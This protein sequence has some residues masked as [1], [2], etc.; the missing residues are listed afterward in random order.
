MRP[1]IFNKNFKS[2]FYKAYLA[3]FEQPV[4]ESAK[5]LAE[6][7][8]THN[9]KMDDSIFVYYKAPGGDVDEAAQRLIKS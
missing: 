3:E 8:R 4:L 5:D 7:L 6:A 1:D 2:H 9:T